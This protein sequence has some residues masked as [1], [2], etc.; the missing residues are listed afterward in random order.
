M[1]AQDASGTTVA[2]SSAPVTLSITTPAGAIL[3]CAANPTTAVTGVA[4]F[5]GC[6]ID[7]V[8]TYTL[9]A[10]SGGLTSAVSASF[11]VSA[12]SASKLAF[13]RSPSGSTAGMAFGTQPVVTVQDAGGNT[14]TSSTASVTLSITT[15]AVG[16]PRLRAEPHNRRLRRC[17]LRRLRHRQ[18]PG[19]YTLTAAAAGLTG[20]VSASFTII[21]SGS[22]TKLAFTTSPSG[23]TGGVFLATQPV[24]TVQDAGGNTV[25]SSSAS[26]D[27]SITTP[28]GATLTCH[29]DPTNAFAG[30]ATFAGCKVDKVGTYTL[31]A[32]SGGL[33]SA[34]SASFTITV[35]PAVKLG[36]T[37]QHRRQHVLLLTAQ[38]GHPGRRWQHE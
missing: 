9:T 1:T 13:T 20:A 6:R 38:G 30:V 3:T 21:A 31:T 15:P 22:A 12:G 37:R 36:F 26:V 11:T 23:S 27:L 10:A 32:A 16:H 35:G 33:T 25:T 2:L 8:G 4:I 24:V 17:H 14:V 28:A 7:K 29:H 34:V 18:D 19:T 5:A